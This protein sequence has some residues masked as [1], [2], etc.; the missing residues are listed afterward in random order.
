[1][2]WRPTDHELKLFHNRRM[3]N[4]R[5]V[6]GGL[7]GGGPI[8]AAVGVLGWN[9]TARYEIANTGNAGGS[10]MS[11]GAVF[12]LI[13]VPTANGVYFSYGGE[14]AAGARGYCLDYTSAGAFRWVTTNGTPAG[15]PSATYTA[16]AGDVGKVFCFFGTHDNANVKAFQR[17][18]GTVAQIG[19]NVAAVGFTGA[20]GTDDM[21]IGNDQNATR[22]ATRISIVAIFAAIG[23]VWTT[24]QMQAI[25]D[26][27]ASRGTVLTAVPGET[28]RYLSTAVTPPGAWAPTAGAH[29][30]ATAGA[31]TA[32][33]TKESFAAVLR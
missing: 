11:I 24:P 3:G 15:I 20:A 17:T 23:T 19:A 8:V 25:S 1:M 7:G 18:A 12:R 4:P 16:V 30:L 9:G 28:F 27:V 29:T 21:M 6:A 32:L 26:E 14:P 5:R 33:I 22:P 31:N 2:I 13:S 10:S